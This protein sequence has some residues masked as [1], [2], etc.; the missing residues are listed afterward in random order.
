MRKSITNLLALIATLATA[1][2]AEAAPVPSL[3]TLLGSFNGIVNNNFFTTSDVEGNVLIG[4]NL[5]G[6][7][8]LDTDFGSA[9]GIT[10]PPNFG[11]VNVFGSNTGTWAENGQIVFVGGSNTGTFGTPGSGSQTSGHVFANNFPNDIWAQMT[12]FSGKLDGLTANSS[13]I[14][15]TF[16]ATPVNNVAVFDVTTARLAALTG[17]VSFTGCSAPTCADI[18][19]VIGTGSY[20]QSFTFPNIGTPLQNVIFNFEDLTGTLT[21]N[22]EWEASI[23]DPTAGS[24]VINTAA[25]EGTLVADSYG[26]NGSLGSGELHNHL[27]DCAADVCTTVPE[28]GSLSLLGSAFASFAALASFAAVRRRRG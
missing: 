7:G 8:I 14:G 5:G 12:G 16:A 6:N 2:T 24:E 4:G 26:G 10:P 20:T 17:V 22:N 21:V 9:N 19:N 25:I 18:I 28:P 1:A 23:L 27:F 13:L 15:N 3:T 11:N